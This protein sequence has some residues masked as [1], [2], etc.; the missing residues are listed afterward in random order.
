M[1]TL[2]LLLMFQNNDK[3]VFVDRVAIKVNDKII[4]EREVVHSYKQ[5]RIDIMQQYTGAELDEKLKK[6]WAETIEFLEERLLLYEKAVELGI[7]VSEDDA[8]SRLIAVQESNGLSD[9]EFEQ[10]LKDQTGMTLAEYVDFQKRE[11]SADMVIR[12]QVLSR[13]KIEDSE[14]AK[15]YD[16][17]IAD[18]Q[19]PATYRIAELVFLKGESSDQA[20][21]KAREALEFLNFNDDFGAAAKRFS[22]S[23]SRD[24]GGDLGLVQYGDFN[25]AIEDRVK[26]MEVGQ[27]SEPFETSS[28]WFVIKLLERNLATPKKVEE[29]REEILQQLR[30]P[31]ME[32]EMATFL[33][34][35]KGK[36]LLHT[37]LKEPPFYLE[38]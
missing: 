37:Y 2:L 24:N 21:A 35:L 7:A 3:T 1:Y 38:L 11:Q 25:Q 23:T 34:E 31:R 20:L 13:I 19:N 17:H 36:Y 14:I 32:T 27:I 15:F 18:F 6:A 16:E 4:T 26:A 10:V 5:S 12:S 8:R 29:V 30:V 28:A 9:E 22:D 33:D